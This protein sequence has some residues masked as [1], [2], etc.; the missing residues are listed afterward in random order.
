MLTYDTTRA[1]DHYHSDSDVEAYNKN[2]LD[3][4]YIYS[5]T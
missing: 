5:Y 3:K 2:V 1:L 4:I